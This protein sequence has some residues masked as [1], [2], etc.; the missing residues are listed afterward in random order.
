MRKTTRMLPLAAVAIA[1]MLLVGCAEPVEVRV[2]PIDVPEPVET[3]ST[4]DEVFDTACLT[5][6]VW[7]LDVDDLAKQLLVLMQSQG[8]PVTSVTGTG[9]MSML[10]AEDAHTNAGMDVTFT[11]VMPLDDGTIAT[12]VYH[13]VGAGQGEWFWDAT[14][15]G[16]IAFEGWEDEYDMTMTVTIDGATVV[17]PLNVPDPGLDGTAMAVQCDGDFLTT[18]SLDGVFTYSWKAVDL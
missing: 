13:Q 7:S 15:P 17:V 6:R 3:E 5:D 16:H 10:L 2:L 8:S 11:M 18:T 14:S 1:A 9:E 4:A 12:G